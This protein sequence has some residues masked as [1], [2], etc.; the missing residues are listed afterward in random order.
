MPF[1]VFGARNEGYSDDEILGFLTQQ[2]PFDLSG[3]RTEGYTDPEIID[4]L[5]NVGVAQQQP[6]ESGFG[7]Q[8]AGS[9]WD[10]FTKENPRLAGRAVEGLGRI[11]GSD[12]VTQWGSEIV[13]DFEAEPDKEAF[14]PRVPTFTQIRD[15]DSAVDFI[16]YGLGQGV[17]SLGVPLAGAVAGGVALGGL[18]AGACRCYWRRSGRDACWG[19]GC[20]FSSELW[21]YL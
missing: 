5:S 3:A 19:W 9:F 1:D 10:T 15:L 11:L 21:R 8:F 4:Y 16:G 7:E 12:T 18:G 20:V 17:A 14:V 6:S 2:N 13:S